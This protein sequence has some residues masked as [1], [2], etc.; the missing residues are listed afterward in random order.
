MHSLYKAT[1]SLLAALL[2]LIPAFANAQPAASE[3]WKGSI[4]IPGQAIVFEITFAVAAPG[5]SGAPANDSAIPAPDAPVTATLSIPSQGIQD[6]ACKDVVF[7]D[8]A[9]AFVLTLPSPEQTWPA[10]SATREP[11][12]AAKATGTM[13]QAGM[14]FP[15]TLER[16]A[17]GEEIAPKRPQEPTPPFPYTQREVFALNS[18][19][20]TK[21][22]G[23]L[24]IPEAAKFGPGPHP[25]ALLITG[26]GMQDRDESLLG[27]KP[28]LVLA[29]HLTRAGIAVLRVDDRGGGKSTTGKPLREVTTDDFVGDA[30]A[31]VEFL[32]SQ[33]DIDAKRIGLIGHSEGGLIAPMVVAKSSSVAYIVLLAG[34]GVNGRE[35][36]IEQIPA[37]ARAA[38]ASPETVA[39]L[40]ERTAALLDAV[41]K[42]DAEATRAAAF[43]L[44]EAD[45]DA[46][47]MSADTR[48][49]IAASIA[50][51]FSSAWFKRFLVLDPAEALRKVRVPTLVLN[52][53]LDMQVLPS[54]NLPPIRAA[55]AE[56]GADVTIEELPGLNHLFQTA[57]TGSGAE[58]AEIEETMAP[59]ALEKVSAWVRA[60]TGV[61]K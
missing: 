34:T 5:A 43:A 37:G 50:M 60:K 7:T 45:P 48:E 52:G 30:I 54:Q 9:I 18:A 28:F 10:F 56:G 55:L 19:D 22:A 46:A 3:R 13:K 58:Y 49:Q 17:E 39:L 35:V 12:G 25:A 23:T 26:S 44:T 21:L 41:T 15:F 4:T 29:D 59:L 1:L 40:R 16:L 24:T 20:G 27:H 8:A 32:A 11:A 47:G 53:S 33:P 61:T 38:G 2:A 6:S 42:D 31:C 36:L 14:D 51:Q 57:K